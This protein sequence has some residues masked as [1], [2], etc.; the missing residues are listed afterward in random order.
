MD[1][2]RRL[3][4]PADPGSGSDGGFDSLGI[5]AT[6]AFGPEVPDVEVFASAVSGLL[7][8]CG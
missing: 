2:T 4:A 1:G 7:R 6:G 8:P 5:V 3:F